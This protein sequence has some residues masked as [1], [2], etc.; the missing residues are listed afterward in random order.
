MTIQHRDDTIDSSTDFPGRTGPAATTEAD[1]R[2]A[3]RA[4]HAS[5]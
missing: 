2:K 3:G 5:H 1:P 4:A